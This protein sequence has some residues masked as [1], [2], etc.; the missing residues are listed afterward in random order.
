MKTVGKIDRE[1]YKCVTPN[2]R[3]D[4]VILTDERIEHI[5]EH[6]PNDYE[7]YSRYIKDMVENPQYIVRDTDPHTAVILKQYTDAGEQFRLI[8]RL[9][10]AEDEDYKKN[11]VITFLK[12][13]EKT[14]EKYIRKY[15]REEKILYKAE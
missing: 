4:E 10:V 14:Y 11:S 9:S 8:L 5:R 6:H 12:I 3:T 15:T 7:R 1:I 13:S 2:I